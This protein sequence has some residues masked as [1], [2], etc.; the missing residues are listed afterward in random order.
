MS[1]EKTIGL[2]FNDGSLNAIIIIL[3]LKKLSFITVFIV[4][5]FLA[6]L[7]VLL[8]TYRILNTIFIFFVATD[9]Y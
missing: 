3:K 1:K 8:I 4:L 2:H 5:A 7:H 6:C 9:N